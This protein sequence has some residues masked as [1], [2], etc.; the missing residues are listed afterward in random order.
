MTALTG[1][2]A[3]VR[4]IMRR[5][6]WLLPLWVLLLAAY[7]ML[8]VSATQDLNPTAAARQSYVESIAGNSGFLMLEGPVFGSSVGALATWRAGDA[9]W[10]VALVSLLTVI[11]HT[12]ADEEVGR[13]ELLGATVVARH[14]G[15]VAALVVTLGANLVLALVA[16]LGLISQGLPAGGSFALGLKIGVVG[17]MFAAIAAFVAQ[18]TEHAA[19]ARAIAVAI[20]GAAF[21]TRAVGD[22]G[23]P[24]GAASW[25]S[26]LS[27]LGWAHQLRPYA[28]ERWWTL[29][30]ALAM[31]AAMVSLAVAF[32]ARRDVAA[33]LVRPRLGPPTAS[34]ALR[35]PVGLA[36]RLH[37]NLLLGW[38]A[39]F[40]VIGGVLGVSAEGAG[41]MFRESQ[42]VE[43][44]FGRLSGRGG[45]SDLF[46]S[47]VTGMLGL[48]AAAYAVQA[49]LRL[50]AEEVALRA[51]PVL[52]TA[53][54][55]RRWAGSHLVFCLLGPAV[56]LAAAGLAGGL[57]YGSSVSDVGRELPRVLAGAMV[58]LPAVWMLA[59]ITVALFG[60]LPRLAMAGWAA[61]GV[62]LAIWLLGATLELNQQVLNISPFTHLPKIPGAEMTTLPLVWLLAI[63][64]A[65]V[66]TGLAAVRSRD[67]ART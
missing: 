37:R 57:V 22:A 27:P 26:W 63:T 45:P 20:L 52:A 3:L 21:L 25:L 43:E 56:A 10:I 12:R 7:P 53:V 23:G 34:Q 30:P 59:A 40:A 54:G 41:E 38:T 14:A 17:W 2:V 55:R 8:M 67:I 5:D 39:G 16:T 61:L 62:V 13:R 31:V 50:R 19:T 28:G 47:G 18:L 15:L 60:I 51:E 48:L 58:Q 65:L 46:L 11:R 32:S 33:G 4:L 6:R 49:T 24:D 9:L 1:T 29:A 35:G 64:A 66:V 42:Q 44:V 36:W